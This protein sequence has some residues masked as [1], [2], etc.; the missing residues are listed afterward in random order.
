[1]SP[2][3]MAVSWE[4]VTCTPQTVWLKGK[5]IRS[6]TWEQPLSCTIHPS[7][8]LFYTSTPVFINKD[9]F[10]LLLTWQLVVRLLKGVAAEQRHPLCGCQS[11][12]CKRVSRVDRTV[13]FIWKT[14]NVFLSF[15]FFTDRELC[16]SWVRLQ[17]IPWNQHL[18]G[19]PSLPVLDF[20]L[21]YPTLWQQGEERGRQRY[22]S[23]SK[24]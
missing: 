9:H 4:A 14:L 24:V 21:R 22:Y 18:R 7:V 1:M 2:R 16:V 19:P 23:R 17:Y 8:L 12:P 20:S 15:C 11:H 5:Q 13:L 10:Q 6:R 3:A